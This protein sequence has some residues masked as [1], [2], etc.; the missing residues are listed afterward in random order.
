MHGRTHVCRKFKKLLTHVPRIVDRS[1]LQGF[2][3]PGWTVYNVL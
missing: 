3:G 1:Y 2:A